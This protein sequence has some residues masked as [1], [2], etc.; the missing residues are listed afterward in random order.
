MTQAVKNP[1]AIQ[2]TQ[3]TQDR[4]QDREDPLLGGMANHSNILA[5]KIS[6]TEEPGGFTVHGVTKSQTCLSM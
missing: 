1:P 6:R 5:W 2:K 3:K 4:S